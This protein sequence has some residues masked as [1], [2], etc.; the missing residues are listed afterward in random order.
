MFAAHELGLFVD[1]PYLTLYSAIVLN[2]RMLFQLGAGEVGELCGLVAGSSGY[3]G[4]LKADHAY[5]ESP[6]Q[7]STFLL[8]SFQDNTPSLGVKV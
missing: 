8:S 5:H 1:F 2:N 7:A 6:M 4:Q 3:I